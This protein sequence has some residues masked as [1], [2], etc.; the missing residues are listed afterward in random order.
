MTTKPVIDVFEGVS[1]QIDP[2]ARL[3]A[4]AVVIGDV[5]IGAGSS[6]WWGVVVRGD[7][8]YIRI[9]ER[10]NVQDGTIIHVSFETAPTEI[11][12]DVVIGHGAKLH[13]CTI[14]DG[15]LIGIG[16]IVLDGATVEPG[17]FLAAGSMLT[18][19]KT[20]GSGEL[21]AGSPAKKLRDLNEDDKHYIK[22]DAA[23]YVKLAAKSLLR[24]GDL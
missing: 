24:A 7:D 5:H 9:G 22:W 15:A 20:V 4:N 21:W 6:L 10:T 11:G 16:A 2:E 13:G 18:P 1:P 23:H 8:H 3:A 12:N 19:G 14:G 17:G